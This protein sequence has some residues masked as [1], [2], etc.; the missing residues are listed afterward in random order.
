MEIGIWDLG[1]TTPW[2][3][4]ITNLNVMG[5]VRGM[6]VICGSF[7]AFWADQ[8]VQSV[9]DAKQDRQ[10][11]KKEQRT[12]WS[13]MMELVMN[14]MIPLRINSENRNPTRSGKNKY[15]MHGYVPVFIARL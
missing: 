15:L 12:E 5:N 1:M 4:G 8:D 13:F 3:G 6:H 14:T 2:E 9:T 10:S 11:R 7:I